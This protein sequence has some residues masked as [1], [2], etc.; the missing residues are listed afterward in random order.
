MPLA[1]EPCINFS[2]GT[3]A[4]RGRL[5][6]DMEYVQEYMYAR[7]APAGSL[8]RPV[9]DFVQPGKC[10]GGKE[11]R[12]SLLGGAGIIDGKLYYPHI[13]LAVDPHYPDICTLNSVYRHE[14]RHTT[15]RNT[16]APYGCNETVAYMRLTAATVAVSAAIK[17]YNYFTDNEITAHLSVPTAVSMALGYSTLMAFG[18]LAAIR[19]KA[20]LS[21]L[22]PQEIDADIFAWRN[23]N[24]NP[25]TL[26]T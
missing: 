20:I 6:V 26:A 5:D 17:D 24:F 11:A 7:G 12:G 10:L 16:S 19:P 21:E 14:L 9:V 1:D 2:S 3:E 4:L 25:I 13:Q 22:A 8:I 23:K 18:A 15:Q